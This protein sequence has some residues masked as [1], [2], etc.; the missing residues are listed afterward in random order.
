M[1]DISQ[2]HYITQDLPNYSHEEQAENACRG[3]VRWV[4][5]RIKKNYS[6]DELVKIANSLKQI[7]VKYDA[8]LIINDR[9]NLA[10]AIDADGVHLGKSDMEAKEAREILGEHK[11]IGNTCNT[12]EDLIHA[13]SKPIDYVGLGPFRFTNTKSNLS[14]VLGMKG[15]KDILKEAKSQIPVVAIGGIVLNDLEQLFE[16]GIHGVALC[17]VIN[18]AKEPKKV[19]EEFTQL[20]NKIRNNQS[21]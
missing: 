1:K 11:I 16:T 5:L 2:F 14:P 15:Y 19:A 20:V 3:G 4:Q 13:Q 21:C 6:E 7:C 10:K 9:V 12:L 8:K 18:L 17:S